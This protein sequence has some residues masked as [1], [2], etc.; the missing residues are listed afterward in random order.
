MPTVTRKCGGSHP[1]TIK[2]FILTPQNMAVDGPL[3]TI[4]VECSGHEYQDTAYGKDIRLMNVKGNGTQ[5]VCSVC[6]KLHNV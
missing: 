6:S 5:A 2:T 4:I 1:I 3:K